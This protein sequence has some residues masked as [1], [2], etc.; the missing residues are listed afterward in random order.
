M[1]K[2][3]SHSI[4]QEVKKALIKELHVQISDSDLDMKI[5][6]M[7][8]SEV[9]D[10][11]IDSLEEK[12]SS[13]KICK[14]VYEVFGIDL[15]LALVLNKGVKVL[16]QNHTSTLSPSRVAIDTYLNQHENVLTGRDIRQMINQLLGINLDGIASLEREKISLYSKG[17]WIVQNEQALFIVQTSIDD[18]DV[19]VLPTEYFSEQTG[20][21]M[22]PE[23]LQLS[24]SNLGFRYDDKIQGFNF[25]NANGLAV[26]DAFKGK[27]IGAIIDVIHKLYSHL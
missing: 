7:S 9:M 25:V 16:V 2:L 19:Q 1:L 15:D 3:T 6:A 11:Y 5:E 4:E 22:L 23:D 17:Q 12:M 18:V 20:L 14:I 21:E 26:P 13:S 27:T 8:K 24:L 10:I